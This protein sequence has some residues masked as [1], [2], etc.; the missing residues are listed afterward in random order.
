MIRV[1]V[2]GKGNLGRAIVNSL[3]MRKKE[4]H[5]RWVSRKE[6]MSTPVSAWRR[7]AELADLPIACVNTVALTDVDLCETNPALAKEIT[8]HTADRLVELSA[9]Y[10]WLVVNISSD[11]VYGDY[12][13]T[14]Y[15]EIDDCM[16]I[17]RY[18]YT[19]LCA[20]YILL[21]GLDEGRVLNVRTNF[22]GCHG[23]YKPDIAE[24][25][26]KSVKDGQIIRGFVDVY[27]S[28]IHVNLLVACLLEILKMGGFDGW[29]FNTLN[30]GSLRP[31]SKY[32]FIKEISGNY[33]RLTPCKIN[34]FAFK[35]KRPSNM[36][37]DT[38]LM[39]SLLPFRKVMSRKN[40]K[41]GH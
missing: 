23:G 3:S 1:I 22:Y 19:K 2:L 13:T 6:L 34:S 26:S 33:E 41:Y 30:I 18:G 21:N 10:S 32:E 27:F 40:D 8:L 37:L 11:Q 31:K 16:P 28:P 7:S 20:E 9:R 14:P 25:I 12:K 36:A 17:N 4:F 15:A 38:R 39:F 35:A 29:Y 5:V 24:W